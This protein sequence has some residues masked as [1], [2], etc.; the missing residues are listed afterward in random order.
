MYVA[1]YLE[2]GRTGIAEG[3]QRHIFKNTFMNIIKDI[4][5]K[6]ITPFAK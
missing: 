2:G 4:Q 3:H 1:S 6:G 5:K